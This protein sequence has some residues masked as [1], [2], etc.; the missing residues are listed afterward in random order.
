MTLTIS[1][2]YSALVSTILMGILAVAGYVLQVGDIWKLDWHT[3]VNIG[4][5]A[6]LT[7]FVSLLKTVLTSDNGVFAGVIQV[8]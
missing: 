3:L 7:G 4:I 1:N 5:M 2:F 8:K 6:I